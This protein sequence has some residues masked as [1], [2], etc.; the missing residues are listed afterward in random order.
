MR[1]SED[2]IKKWEGCK[3]KAYNCSAGKPTIGWG[4][5][6]YINGREV[7][8]GDEITQNQA[9]SMLSFYVDAIEKEIKG[10]V[11]HNLTSFQLAAL[12]SFVYNL[13]V[14]AFKNSTLLK[15]INLSEFDKAAD[16]FMKWVYVTD[17]ET[18]NKIKLQ[19]LVN[20]RKDERELFIRN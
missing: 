9:D 19:G 17:P 7:R 11:K 18:K 10:F 6:R 1:L 12:T 13:G 2:L 16:E 8:I 3:L 15:K 20:R 4:S 14:G 5:T